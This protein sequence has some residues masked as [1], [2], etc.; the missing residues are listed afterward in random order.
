MHYQPFDSLKINWLIFGSN[1]MTENNTDSIITQFNKCSRCLDSYVK[2]LTKVSSIC[3][4]VNKGFH[5][6]P[7]VLNVYNGITKN[8][9][10]EIVITSS[11]KLTE[12]IKQNSYFSAPIY[13]AHYMCQ[14]IRTYVER[15]IC[16]KIFLHVSKKYNLTDDVIKLIKE[17]ITLFIK[18]LG[19]SQNNNYEIDD[20]YKKTT[21][22][23]EIIIFLKNYFNSI[24]NNNVINTNLIN[25]SLKNI[26]NINL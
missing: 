3:T 4:D 26:N 18:F 20:I 24:D 19:K 5:P 10:N 25:F 22:P 9:Y 11:I 16:S 13:I 12:E 14:D 23:K 21:L 6:N 17:N 8:I 7:H 15:K 1:N 2:C